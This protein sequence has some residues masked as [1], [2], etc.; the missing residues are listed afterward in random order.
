MPLRLKDWALFTLLA[1]I[2]CCQESL[3]GAPPKRLDVRTLA[4]WSLVVDPEAAA[5]T[6]AVMPPRS[7]SYLSHLICESGTQCDDL[8]SDPVA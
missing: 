2:G 8:P 7:R 3:L 1:V 6:T 5:S 4:D